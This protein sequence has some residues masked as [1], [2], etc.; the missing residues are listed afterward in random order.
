MLRRRW[1]NVQKRDAPG[2]A[3]PLQRGGRRGTRRPATSSAS[4]L[5]RREKTAALHGPGGG[6]AGHDRRNASEG[7]KELSFGKKWAKK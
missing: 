2:R 6:L 1:I 4:A 3:D 5:L 7:V